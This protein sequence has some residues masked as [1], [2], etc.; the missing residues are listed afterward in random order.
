MLANNKR[1]MSR[2]HLFRYK[3]V[4]D[5]DGVVLRFHN[6]EAVC[7]HFKLTKWHLDHALLRSG[8]Y[9]EQIG[10]IILRIH[11]DWQGNN[12]E[13]RHVDK[14][15]RQPSGPRLAERQPRLAEHDSA[16]RSY[17]RQFALPRSTTAAAAKRKSSTKPKPFP[18]LRIYKR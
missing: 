2:R 6:K 9:R 3:F 15:F 16:S 14:R 1:R 13:V 5:Q 4:C 18:F 12:V 8:T 10:G 17:R 7:E 11:E